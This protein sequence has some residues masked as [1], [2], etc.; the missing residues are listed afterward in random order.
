MS[1]AS[2]RVW[3][4]SLRLGLVILG[5]LLASGL[6]APMLGLHP[7]AVDLDQV[8]RSPSRDHWMGTDGLGRDVAARVL[9][10]SRVSLAVGLLAASLSLLVGMPLGAIA[11][12]GGLPDRFVSRVVES[13]LCIPAL[14]LALCLL[15]S[16]PRWLAS[17]PP[18]IRVAVVLAMTGW[19]PVARYLRGEFLK[20][21]DTDLVA[22]ARAAGAGRLRIMVK[23][24]LP[25]A[26]APVVVTAAFAVAASILLEA[27]LSFLGLG[28]PPPTPT[29]GGLLSEARHHVLHAWWLALFPGVALFLALLACNLL[30][31]GLRARLD[32]RNR[33]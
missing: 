5:I 21:K 4:A 25:S 16:G 26:L 32:P 28:V 12:S 23:H 14:V 9:A 10:G 11:G 30:G 33:A 3:P 7:D 27:G 2:R 1:R 24:L 29:W 8:L 20:L 15:T 17:L 31:E 18:S 22:S 19:T 6:A 13:V